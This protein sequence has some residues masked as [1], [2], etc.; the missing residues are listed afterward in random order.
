MVFKALSVILCSE[1]VL[2]FKFLQHKEGCLCSGGST[3]FIL[4]LP[5][6]A[7]P[8]G[9]GLGT[10]RITELLGLGGTSGDHAVQPP[11]KTGSPGEDDTEL[12]Q[13]DIEGLQQKLLWV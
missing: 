2:C 3:L 6:N 11:A 5:H 8:V 1:T 9:C 7:G 4:S 12:V 10:R 13:V